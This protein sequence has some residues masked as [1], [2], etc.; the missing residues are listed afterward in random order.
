MS[1]PML[2]DVPIEWTGNPL[3]R[4]GTQCWCGTIR[5]E[6]M[7]ID[8]AMFGDVGTTPQIRRS[9]VLNIFDVDA[10]WIGDACLSC[11]VLVNLMPEAAKREAAQLVRWAAVARDG[12]A[13]RPHAHHAAAPTASSTPAQAAA[14]RAR[15]RR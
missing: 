4:A 3:Y 7:R 8:A 12:T 2:A 15:P 14:S 10:L 6:L 11:V 5:G 9:W 13:H 1:L